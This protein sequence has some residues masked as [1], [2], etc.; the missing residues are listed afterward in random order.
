MPPEEI[1]GS[2]AFRLHDTYGFPLELTVEIAR[3]HGFSVDEAGFREE[4]ERQR[5]RARA[6]VRSGEA[7]AVTQAY[8]SLD[9]PAS[10]FAGYESI[11]LKTTVL[12]VLPVDGD[13]LREVFLAETPFYPEGGGQVGDRGEI[14][15]PNGRFAVEDTQRVAERLIAHRGHVV[16][17][18]LTEG[19]TVT[20]RVDESL[21]RD[22]MRNHTGTHLLHA[23]L[24]QVLGSHVRQAGSLVEAGRLRFDFTHSQALTP[25][26]I[27]Q[28]EG[29]VNAKVRENVP[30]QTRETTFDEAMNEGALAFFGEKY[31]EHVRVVEVD[32]GQL[33]PPFDSPPD[34]GTVGGAFSAELCGGTHCRQTGDIGLLL[35]VSESSV[36]SGARRIEALTGR[37][38]EEYVRQ[39]LTALDEIAHRLGSP[40]EAVSVKTEALLAEVDSQRKR[41]ERLE[42]SLASAPNTSQLLEKAVDVDGVRV[43][44]ARVDAPSQD[45]LR[46]LGDAVRNGIGS[47]AAVLGTVIDERPFFLALVTRDLTSRLQAGELLQQVAAVTG[48][49]GGGRPD[50]AQGG[51]K[52]ASRLDEALKLAPQ[53]V[54]EML[55]RS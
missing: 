2:E 8:A 22:T 10:T 25:E 14:I 6:A 19:E 18:T 16:E 9:L 38:A 47:G 34:G 11:D 45:A 44:A 50:L 40:R 3:G 46:Y 23:A 20:A 33:L 7:V 39:H 13:N 29:L 32:G 27:A 5:K 28:V 12:A 30:V 26:Q 54:R 1:T 24:R 53:L 15:G 51:G 17:G 4:M 42:R 49:R 43:L 48:G 41:I 37:G 52:D 31:G 55:Q 35:I 21:R 36:G